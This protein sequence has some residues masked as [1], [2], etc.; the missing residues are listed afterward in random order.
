[1]LRTISIISMSALA[2]GIALVCAGSAIAEDT[3]PQISAEIGISELGIEDTTSVGAALNAV[4]VEEPADIE[5]SL[6]AIVN[7]P[8]EDASYDAPVAEQDE[9]DGSP[10]DEEDTTVEEEPSEA[11]SATDEPYD[12]KVEEASPCDCGGGVPTT[13]D[14]VLFET[15]SYEISDDTRYMLDALA[16]WL[17]ESGTMVELSGHG[18]DVGTERYN[19]YLGFRRAMVI[20]DHLISQ[21]VGG[22]QV[23]AISLGETDPACREDFSEAC[24]AQ[25]RRVRFTFTAPAPEQ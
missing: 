23:E 22:E 15:N 19:E 4:S 7:A 20:K 16:F 12:Y 2:L 3:Q 24:R 1:M 11:E 6:D 25:N 13:F 5:P 8:A 18:D 21:G 17:A 10:K 9:A 14:D